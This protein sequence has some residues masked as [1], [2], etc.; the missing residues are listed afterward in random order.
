MTFEQG[1]SGSDHG[2]SGYRAGC[3]ETQTLQLHRISIPPQA[4]ILRRGKPQSG[5]QL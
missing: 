3:G 4:L 1:N 2:D 5:D